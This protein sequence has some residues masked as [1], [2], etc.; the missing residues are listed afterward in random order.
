MFFS[1]LEQKFSSGGQKCP[2]YRIVIL[3]INIIYIITHPY[4]DF[5]SKTKTNG[6]AYPP[7]EIGKNL[8][9]PLFL[10]LMIRKRYI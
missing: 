5:I 1:L 3:N 10:S 4:G 2:P 6:Y 7:A 8:L 9:C